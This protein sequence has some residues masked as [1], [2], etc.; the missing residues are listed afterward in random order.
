[1]KYY[2]ILDHTADLRILVR[3]KDLKGLFINAARAMFEIMATRAKDVADKK[4]VTVTVTAA[5]VEELFVAWLNELLYLSATSNVVFT[6]FT[7]E[8]LG[9]TSL[10]AVAA[11]GPSKNFTL[12]KDIKA[13]T[14]HALSITQAAGEWQAQ[15]IFDV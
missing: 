5:N 6:D 1:M 9:E 13:A 10:R 12:L 7:V 15:V 3:A 11:A 14:Y 4:K 2:E 8:A